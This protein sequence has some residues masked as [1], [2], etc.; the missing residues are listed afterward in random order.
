M[1]IL[2]WIGIASLALAVVGGVAYALRRDPI[3]PLAGRQLTGPVVTEPVQ[4]W[5][6][7]DEHM[8]IAVETR[9]GDPH[10]VTTVCFT[11]DG[12]LYVPA[13]GGSQKQWTQH[14]MSDPRVRV[15]IDGKVYPA[16]AERVTDTS[17]SA[18][19]RAAAREKYDLDA[20][21]A[22]PEDLW[23]FRLRSPGIDVAAP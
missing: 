15:K 16:L 14:V 10:S 7:S 18:D 22:P 6:F 17:R 12:E 4:D 13:T 21:A 8:L 9:L 20:N 19:I 1:R 23:V 11:V 2:K 5:S 3:G